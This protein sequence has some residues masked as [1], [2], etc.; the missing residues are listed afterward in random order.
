[1]I[2]NIRT[3]ELLIGNGIKVPNECEI[4]NK[5]IARK[6]IVAKKYIKKGELLSSDNLCVKDLEGIS[7]MQWDNLIGKISQQNYNNDDLIEN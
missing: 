5:A 1:M 3:T 4:S 7:P 2:E 6:S